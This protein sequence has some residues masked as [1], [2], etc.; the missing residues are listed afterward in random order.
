MSIIEYSYEDGI[1]IRVGDTIVFTIT[2]FD[3]TSEEPP[4]STY[5]GAPSDIE[6]LEVWGENEGRKPFLITPEAA[7]VF[8]N[9]YGGELQREILLRRKAIN[10][11]WNLERKLEERESK[12]LRDN[13]WGI[14]IDR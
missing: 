14:R 8:V 2:K 9:L 4:S 13:D 7:G 11:S 3:F 10:E 12:R 1:K 6:V 5:P